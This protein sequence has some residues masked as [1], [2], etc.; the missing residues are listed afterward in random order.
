MKTMYRQSGVSVLGILLIVAL[1]SF[2]LTVVMRLMPTYMEGRAVR[3]ALA[4]VVENANPKQS[5]REVNRSV[6][7]TFVTNQI[8]GI[9]AKEVKV[10]RDKGKILIDARYEART[11]LFDG[12]D[13]VLVFDDLVFTIE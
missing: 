2:F 9:K 5:L 7:T 3:T 12:V 4:G 10:Y 8:N 11:R 6:V 13:A 1:F